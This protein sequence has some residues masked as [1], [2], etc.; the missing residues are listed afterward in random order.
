MFVILMSYDKFIDLNK[1]LKLYYIYIFNY[2]LYYY[3]YC[4]IDI[5]YQLQ[6]G[7]RIAISHVDEIEIILLMSLFDY[8]TCVRIATVSDAVLQ[9]Q[10]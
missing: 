10:I 6:L 1:I 3:Y 9:N 4:I 5:L 7:E 8:V 2:L